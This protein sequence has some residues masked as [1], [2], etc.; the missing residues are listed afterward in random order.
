MRLSGGRQTNRADWAAL[1]IDAWQ[2][3]TP[4]VPVFFSVHGTGAEEAVAMLERRLGIT[5]YA[6]MD[7]AIIAAIA[8]AGEA[9]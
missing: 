5:P 6:T 8:A 1:G 4:D 9:S 7:E 2:A 3:L